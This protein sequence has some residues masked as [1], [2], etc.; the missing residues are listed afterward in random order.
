MVGFR[1]SH[2][3][4]PRAVSDLVVMGTEGA[5]LDNSQG[6]GVRDKVDCDVVKWLRD[7]RGQNRFEGRRWHSKVILLKLCPQVPSTDLQT[8]ACNTGINTAHKCHGQRGP[9]RWSPIAFKLCTVGV[10]GE[11]ELA[12]I[13]SAF[14]DSTQE[15]LLFL[16]YILEFFRRFGLKKE[17]HSLETTSFYREET[18]A[19][20]G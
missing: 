12:G 8:A 13:Q 15:S 20:R 16:L 9:H 19:H 17:N 7:Y 14:P 3:W 11:V 18:E 5:V 10:T 2:R 6:L 4:K 1:N